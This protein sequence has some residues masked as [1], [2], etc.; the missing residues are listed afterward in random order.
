MCRTFRFHDAEI[1]RL[2]VPLLAFALVDMVEVSLSHICADSKTWVA[3]AAFEQDILLAG[4]ATST[5]RRL[6]DALQLLHE[7]LEEIPNSFYGPPDAQTV[8]EANKSPGVGKTAAADFYSASNIT[9]A[10]LPDASIGPILHASG[11]QA[12]LKASACS[13]APLASGQT[14]STDEHLAVFSSLMDA[15]AQLLAQKA[16][17]RMDWQ[18]DAWIQSVLPAISALPGTQA[19]FD[20]LAASLQALVALHRAPIEPA[21]DIDTPQTVA[22]L[23]D[24]VSGLPSLYGLKTYTYSCL[25][26]PRQMISFLAPRFGPVHVETVR[27]LWTLEALTQFD[28]IESILCERMSS[29]DEYAQAAAFDAFG[30]LWRLTG[31]LASVYVQVMECSLTTIADDDQL[32]GKFLAGPLFLVLDG[33]KSDNFATRQAAEAWMR[34]HFK[35][36][37]RLL[38]PIMT[39]ATD[40]GIQRS[41][42][43]LTSGPCTVQ[44]QQYVQPF[45]QAR[46]HHALLNLHNLFLTRGAGFMKVAK[47]S[48]LK[49]SFDPDVVRQ[50]GGS[51]T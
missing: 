39:I 47:T 27:L 21:L 36:Y 17:V 12:V 7:I 43:D 24:K 23:M 6:S 42:T 30:T 14:R 15:I 2:H 51:E 8:T 46:V 16:S 40:P 28:Y 50:A 4:G 48:L 41:P 35:S 26:G 32:P 10:R 49:Q 20:C 25:C 34:C 13:A 29:V 19:G 33:S 5:T 45:D 1:Q 44:L 9:E 38:D 22:C 3:D 31:R 18:P 37:V 11:L